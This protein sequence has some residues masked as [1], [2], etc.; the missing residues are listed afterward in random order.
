MKVDPFR[1][2]A[3]ER[4]T[5]VLRRLHADADRQLPGL[6]LHYLPKLPSMLLGRRLNS[7]EEQI[8]GYYA[9]K[10]ICL[11]REQAAFCYLTLR[12]L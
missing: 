1:V 7:T 3:D 5:R 10:Y 4:V 11:D 12:S 8:R 6:I 2:I 9:D